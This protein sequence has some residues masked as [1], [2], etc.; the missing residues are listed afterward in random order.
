[1]NAERFSGKWIGKCPMPFDGH[2][3]LTDSIVIL[4]RFDPRALIIA[5]ASALILALPLHMYPLLAL[6]LGAAVYGG[7]ALLWQ[8]SATEDRPVEPLTP[9]EEA[10]SRMR[11]STA[12]VLVLAEEVEKPEVRERVIKI[13]DTFSTMLDVMEKDKAKNGYASAPEF[14]ERVVVPFMTMLDYYVRL[15]QRRIELVELHLKQ[16]EQSELRRYE[17]LSN[18]FYQHYHDGDVFNFV[19]LLE[20]FESDENEE[21]DETFEDDFDLDANAHIADIDLLAADKRDDDD[22]EERA[23]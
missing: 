14:E 18:S 21:N 1:M 3:L 15:S 4:R 7:V 16:F 5:G 12:Q 19:A 2:R 6:V 9:E 20:M 17:S 10:F 13:G 23:S 8:S 11:A 22:F